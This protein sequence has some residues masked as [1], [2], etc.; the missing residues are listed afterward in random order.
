[1]PT[2]QLRYRWHY[3][4]PIRKKSSTTRYHATREDVAREHPDAV[5]V[6][7]SEQLLELADDPLANSM[8]RFQVGVMGR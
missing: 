3:Y 8:A 7:G 2:T 6:P 4:D 1:M 5:P